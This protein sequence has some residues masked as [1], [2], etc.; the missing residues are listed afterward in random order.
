MLA[1]KTLQDLFVQGKEHEFTD[2]ETT[3]KIYFKKLNSF[4]AETS[5][6]KANAAKAKI[7][8]IKFKADDDEDRLSYYAEVYDLGDSV[9]DLAD[10]VLADTIADTYLKAEQ[11][12][13][14]KDKWKKENRLQGLFDAWRDGLSDEYQMDKSKESVD[15]FEQLQEFSE[16][17]KESA[18]K[19]LEREKRDLVVKP[20]DVLQRN[21]VDKMI[22][23]EAN[24]KWV[25]EYNKWELYYSARDPEDHSVKIFESREFIDEIDDAFYS[26]IMTAYKQILVDD[27]SLKS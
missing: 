11:R 9:E 2:G 26:Q 16:E 8:A 7:G 17:V 21:L 13:S 1:K 19:D 4:E 27:V 18:D 14:E 10:L 22:D 24:R 20:L 5:F 23:I 3:I 6:K 12:I 25:I 15:V